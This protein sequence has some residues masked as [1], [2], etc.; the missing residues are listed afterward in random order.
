M[1]ALHWRDEIIRASRAGDMH[2]IDQLAAQ[3]AQAEEARRLLRAL[4]HCP[5]CAASVAAGLMS[6]ATTT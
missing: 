4:T 1:Q 3:L 6:K 5:T 2:R